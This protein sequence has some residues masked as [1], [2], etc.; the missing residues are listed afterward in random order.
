VRVCACV[1]VRACA[2]WGGG[3]MVVV[4]CMSEWVREAWTTFHYKI[5]LHM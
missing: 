3:G 4:M 1:R 2:C 5:A